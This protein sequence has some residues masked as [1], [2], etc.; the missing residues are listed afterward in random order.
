MEKINKE[1]IYYFVDES[2]DPCFYDRRGNYIVGKEGCSKLLMLGFVKIDEPKHIRKALKDIRDKI[3]NDPYLKDIPSLQKSSRFFHATDDCPEV[4]QEVFKCIAD[5]N[6]KAQFV[7]ARKIEG[8]FKKHGCSEDKFYDY[9]ISQLFKNVLHKAEN[10]FIYF[11]KRGSSNR[12]EPLERA[13]ENAKKHFETKFLIKIRSNVKIQSQI[14]TDEPCLQVIDYMNWAIYRVFVKREMRYF[15]YIK[16]K[17][18]FVWDIYD[19]TYPKN[20]YSKNN[21]FDVKKIS[22]L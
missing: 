3:V 10:N 1:N 4:R 17:I 8:V 13:I 18:S 12:Q 2:G 22:L 9:L 19:T 21:E 16:D 6:F 15:N 14:P 11:S 7:V 5:L 20:Y